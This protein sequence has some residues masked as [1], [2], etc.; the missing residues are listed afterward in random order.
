MRYE[1]EEGEYEEYEG[2]VWHD[3][4]YHMVMLMEMNMADEKM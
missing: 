4:E 2:G 3:D 1:D